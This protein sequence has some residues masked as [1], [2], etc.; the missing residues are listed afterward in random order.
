VLALLALYASIEAPYYSRFNF[1]GII[2][3][4]SLV[5]LG[6]LLVLLKINIKLL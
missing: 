2:I 1:N 5:L 6:P 4:F 3:S